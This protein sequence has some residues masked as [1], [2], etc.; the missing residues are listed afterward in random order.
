M[1]LKL[2]DDAKGYHCSLKPL[3]GSSGNKGPALDTWGRGF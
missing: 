1:D 3:H 2:Y